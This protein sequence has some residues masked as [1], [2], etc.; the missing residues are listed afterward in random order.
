MLKFV[1]AHKDNSAMKEF[2]EPLA[3]VNKE[4]GDITMQI[5]MRAMQNPDEVGAAAVDYL[6]YAGYVTL[7]YLWA[8][9]AQVA[10]SKL[11]EG[12]S[13]VDF[14]NAKVT[15]ARFYFQKILPR[16]RSHVDVLSTGVE[17]LMALDAEHFAF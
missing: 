5:G 7:A 12:S 4:W 6:Y 17:S 8:R 1:E 3:A 11:E 16:V 14:Y 9:M 2:I 10:L 15:T 13:D